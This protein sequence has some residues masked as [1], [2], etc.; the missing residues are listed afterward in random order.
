M[1]NRYVVMVL[2]LV[3]AGCAGA[4][5]QAGAQEPASAEDSASKLVPV[6]FGTLKQDEFTMGLRSGPLLIKVTPMVE[7]VIRL[8]APDTYNRLH[9]LRESR[10]KDAQ[11]GTFGA[12]P[13]MFLV[14]FFSYQPDVPYQPE[15]LQIEHQGRLMR[16]TAIMPL[17]PNW[18]TGRLEQQQIATAIYVFGDAITYELPMI[19]R[20]GMH[21]NAEWQR[22]IPKL[23]VERG[24][25]TGRDKS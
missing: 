8:A 20:Y 4:P 22:I 7:S 25:V 1:R 9:A 2:A 14:S 15:N 3:A 17:S 12:A 21:E 5:R 18:G 13:E 16:A 23:Q 24:K 6:G 10:G 11:A 19:V